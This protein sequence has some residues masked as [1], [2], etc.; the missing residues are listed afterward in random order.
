[1][2]ACRQHDVCE[3]LKIAAGAAISAAICGYIVTR[4]IQAYA[5]V[6]RKASENL[7][8]RDK[9]TEQDEQETAKPA[10]AKS[11]PEHASIVSPRVYHARKPWEI[12]YPCASAMY[13][14]T[15]SSADALQ[16]GHHVMTS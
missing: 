2:S 9:Q 8:S 4:K 10:S 14:R 15:R 1:M 7:E 13:S 6:L 12:S 5:D 11:A 16:S 3:V